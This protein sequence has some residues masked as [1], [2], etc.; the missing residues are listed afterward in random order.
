MAKLQLS[1]ALEVSRITEPVHDGILR[2]A[3]IELLTSNVTSGE[4]IWRQLRFAR[5]LARPPRARDQGVD[6]AMKVWCG[7]RARCGS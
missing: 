6:D 2:P 5:D 3:G 4:L 7:E 1:F